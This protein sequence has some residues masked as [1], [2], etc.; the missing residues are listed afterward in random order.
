MTA[1]AAFVA[2][3]DEESPT[4]V[5]A[6]ATTYDVLVAA[7]ATFSDVL[8]TASAA[9]FATSPAFTASSSVYFLIAFTMPSLS[10]FRGRP[11]RSLLL[12]GI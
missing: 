5:L 10:A 4:F 8:P 9:F 7:S 11:K 6:S 12:C 1:S 3:F 2:N